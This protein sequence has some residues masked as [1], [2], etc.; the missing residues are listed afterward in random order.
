MSILAILNILDIMQGKQ[1]SY[2]PL[3]HKICFFGIIAFHFPS[4]ENNIFGKK[5]FIFPDN[6]GNFTF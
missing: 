2:L 3:M 5:K 6:T 1:I 4:E